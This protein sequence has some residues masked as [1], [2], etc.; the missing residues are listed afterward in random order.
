MTFSPITE[1]GISRSS[2][3][4]SS[5]STL[6]TISLIFSADTGRLWHTVERSDVCAV[7]ACSVVVEAVIAFEIAKAFLD[8]FS[9][10]C[11]ADVK[12]YYDV[13][14]NRIKNF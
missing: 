11:M 2:P 7:P 3:L 13:Y 5:V 12:A 4:K 9:G 6:L 1:L 10:D 14:M 8:K